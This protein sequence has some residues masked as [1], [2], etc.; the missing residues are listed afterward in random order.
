ML[1]GGMS[2]GGG[3]LGPLQAGQRRR[4]QE[5]PEAATRHLE[6]GDQQSCS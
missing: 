5:G 1:Q 2:K 3:V 6:V 4:E